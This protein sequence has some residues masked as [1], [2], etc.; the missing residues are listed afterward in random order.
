M[1]YLDLRGTVRRT[2][3]LA[4]Y[5]YDEIHP[6]DKGFLSLSSKYVAEINKAKMVAAP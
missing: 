1:T 2:D 3:R 6:N 4:D 5:W